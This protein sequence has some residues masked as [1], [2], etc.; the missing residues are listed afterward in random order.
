MFTDLIKIL[1][2]SDNSKIKNISQEIK[3]LLDEYKIDSKNNK[4]GIYISPLREE[5]TFEQ[6]DIWPIPKLI[7]SFLKL[8]S[9]KMAYKNNYFEFKREQLKNNLIEE[10]EKELKFHPEINKKNFVFKNS[11]YDY[12]NN[13]D[14]TDLNK[15]YSNTTHSR[16]S[17]FN[18]LYE[19]FMAEKKMHD[20]ALER[21]RES[22]RIKEEKKC[23]LNPKITEYKPRK[24]YLQNRL[25]KSGIKS[26]NLTPYS[27]HSF[28]L[29]STPFNYFKNNNNEF[30]ICYNGGPKKKI[31]L[32]NKKLNLNMSKINSFS[33]L[34]KYK[35]KSNKYPINISTN[36][37]KE[38]IKYN[39]IYNHLE[40]E[41]NNDKINN[42]NRINNTEQNCNEKK[43]INNYFKNMKNL[44]FN[45]RK[46]QIHNNCK[47]FLVDDYRYYAEKYL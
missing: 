38:K 39:Y 10:K 5:Q 25:N 22:K 33:N 16:K 31:S 35:L 28:F 1:F 11:K 44:K 19:R 43:V 26:R 14:N 13:K 47:P 15:T 12:Y 40:E 30:Y 27:N 3:N 41:K 37:Q 6:K 2:S 24:M 34:K 17:D 45:F 4:E 42:I 8:K 46:I 20:K 9:D 18:K 32:S 29:S 23:T 7:K 36:N 21:L